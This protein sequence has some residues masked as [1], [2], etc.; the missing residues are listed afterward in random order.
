M[1]YI[2]SV[3]LILISIFLSSTAFAQQIELGINAGGASY[4]GD[5]NQYNPIKIS[6]ISAGAFIKVNLDP[7]WAVGLHYN[8]GK[9]KGADSLSSY[10]QFR[11]RN[12]SFYTPLNEVSLLLQFNFFDLYSPGGKRRFSPYI[13]AGI[14]AVVFE[15]KTEYKDNEYLL[16]LYNTEGQ[17]MAYKKHSL[18]IPYG[19]GIKYRYTESL[20]IF[21][22]AGYRSPFTDYIDDV[23]GLYAKNN[24]WS[25]NNAEI[26]RALA[27]RSGE[28]TG[29]YIGSPDTQRGDF[30]K[31]DNYMF[32]GIG[33]SYTFVSQKCFT[34]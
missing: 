25:G 30:R 20:T 23:S 28:K 21:G 10:A 29:N 27:D 16:R 14:G 6:G 32:V 24:S 22:Q 26:S 15:P 7:H 18:T 34:F 5:L 13:F 12:L 19:V 11:D 33:I 4:L 1:R 9:I 8:Y 31:R 17:S 2:K 3:Q